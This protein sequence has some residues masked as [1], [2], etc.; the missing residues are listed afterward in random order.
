MKKPAENSDMADSTSPAGVT[1]DP[2]NEP[3][4]DKQQSG[5]VTPPDNTGNR[6][7]AGEVSSS[8]NTPETETEKSTAGDNSSG[9]KEAPESTEKEEK[10]DEIKKEED[11][12]E[13]I[14]VKAVDYST[15]SIDELLNTLTILVDERP[16]PEIRTDVE[17]IKINFYKKHKNEIEKKKKAFLDE[18]GDIIDFMPGEDPREARLKELLNKYKELKTAYNRDL[19]LQKQTNLQEKY[20][21]IEEIKDLVNRKESINK[22]F[23]DFRELQTR[24]REVGLVPQQNLKDLWETYHHHVEKFYDYIKINK[25]LRDLDL[26]KNQEAKITL[27]ERAEELLLEPSIVNA[28]KKLQK[29][30]DH[31]RETGPVPHEVKSELWERFREAT[32]KINKKH[33]EYYE[34]LKAAQKKNLEAKTQLC[35][36]VEDILNQNLANHRDWEKK[37]SEVVELQKVWRTIGYAPKKS[38]NKI[39]QRF[40]DNCDNFFKRKREF[41]AENKEIQTN[42]LQLKT[43]LCIQAESLMNSTEWKKTTEDLINLQKK[44]KEIGPVPRKH[45]EKIWKRFRAACDTFFQQKSEY[46]SQ[47]DDT[48]EINLKSKI[49]LIEQIEAYTPGENMEENFEKLKEFQRN[50]TE[51]G[52]VPFKEKDKILQQYRNAI[53]K[54]FDNLKVDEDEKN[55]LKYKNKLVNLRDNPKADIKVKQ[56]REKFLSRIKQLESDIVLWENNIGFF[57]KSDN[58]D[59]MINEVNE[60]ID[61]AKKTIRLL[62]DK[63][64]MIDQSDFD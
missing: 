50:W 12:D 46:Y 60:K 29:L 26:K 56:D 34:N 33:Q 54:Q 7:S 23:Q 42:N 41:Y 32:S 49:E 17:N 35:E 62:E 8:E 21:I 22:T 20:Q 15:F 31:W 24:W 19:E 5:T 25:E 6:P 51:I 13:D 39:Y 27:C 18:G 61:R 38:N 4:T 45:S 36:K 16:I 58:A 30:H 2:V 40:R 3:E 1:S 64:R 37:S 52:Y 9:D 44:W 28:F 10:T 47:I 53:N 63:I 55:L 43:E 57:A 48:Y 14:T 11:S 59:S